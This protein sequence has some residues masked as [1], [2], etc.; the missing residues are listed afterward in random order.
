MSVEVR[1]RGRVVDQRF[2]ADRDTVVEECYRARFVGAGTPTS[3]DR[4]GERHGLA[5]QQGG[6]ACGY[7]DARG[8][9]YGRVDRHWNAGFHLHHAVTAVVG[10][11]EVAAAIHRYT[12]GIRKRGV[13]MKVDTPFGFTSNTWL[14]YGSAMNTL[15]LPSTATPVGKLSPDA[16]VV[17]VPFGWTSD[18][19]VVTGVR[20]K[21]VA[22]TIDRHAVGLIES[23][24]DS[25]FRAVWA[26]LKHLVITG[27]GDE[28]V[29]AA[30]HRQAVGI[31]EPRG[32]DRRRA[33]RFEL[34]HAVV[35]E[36]SNE[37]V[38]AAVH[39]H[40]R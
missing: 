26:D 27:V 3:G 24:S 37:D 35:T 14:S 38:A 8:R 4:R 21:H 36:I 39:R 30:V 7:A 6:G 15:P 32:D 11:E 17:W 33:E 12:H 16:M 2:G 9:E 28:D 18:N 20:D 31:R 13:P 22:L 1:Q 40:A 19:S 10:D 29:T 34:D 23:C 5:G 25:C